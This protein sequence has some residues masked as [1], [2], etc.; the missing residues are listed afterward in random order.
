MAPRLLTDRI[1]S[2]WDMC[3]LEGTSLQRGMNFR[4]QPDHSVLLTSVLPNAPYVD[5]FEDDGTTLI[6]EGHDERRVSGAPD[7]KLLDQPGVYPGGGLTQNGKFYE[8]ARAFKAGERPAERV[9]VY[10]KLRPG[11]WA[12]NGVFH[13]VDAWQEPSARRSVFKFRLVAV[14]SDER[15][16]APA[17]PERRRLIPG[18]VKRAVWIR[19]GGRCV[20]CGATDDLHFDHVI[21]YSRG[22]SSTSV[23]N[24]QLLCARHNLRKGARIA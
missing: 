1:L 2:Y 23:E 15:R 3:R 21:P 16:D 7:P 17:L 10:E 24:V 8:A 6:Y 19:D 14:E 9:R 11:I 13:L 12:D 4:L 20:E 22:G 5:R 18:A